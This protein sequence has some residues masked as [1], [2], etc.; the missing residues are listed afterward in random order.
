MKRV[1]KGGSRQNLGTLF[2]A[3]CRWNFELSVLDNLFHNNVTNLSIILSFA[4]STTKLAEL[5]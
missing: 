1:Q 2:P 4:T 5:V 3:L